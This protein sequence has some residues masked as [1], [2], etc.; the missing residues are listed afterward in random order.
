MTKNQIN[1]VMLKMDIGRKVNGTINSD[2]FKNFAS[3]LL[4]VGVID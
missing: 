2:N 3:K 4:E 1:S